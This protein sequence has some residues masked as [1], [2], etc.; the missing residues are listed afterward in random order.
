MVKPIKPQASTL[1]HNDYVIPGIKIQIE[2]EPAPLRE[3]RVS[4]RTFVQMEELYGMTIMDAESWKKMTPQSMRW[5]LLLCLQ[6][7]D[8]SLTEEKIRKHVHH[9]NMFYLIEKLGEAWTRV[10]SREDREAQN[11]RPF[12]L[13]LEKFRELRAAA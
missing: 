8:S 4:F 9:G 10:T 13:T 12:E 2:P 7:E 5:M 6:H 1:K 3:L 11:I